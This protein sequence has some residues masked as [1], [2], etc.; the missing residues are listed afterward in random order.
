MIEIGGGIE[1]GPGI[2][3]NTSAPVLDILYFITDTASDFIVSE[4][5]D[6]FI[7]ELP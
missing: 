7:E 5:N 2:T 3:I 6:N 4:N 1:I